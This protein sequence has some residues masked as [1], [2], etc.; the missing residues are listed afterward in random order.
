M[1]WSGALAG[2]EQA[3]FPMLGGLLPYAEAVFNQRQVPVLISELDRLPDELRG[4]WVD[5]V[6]ILGQVVLEGPHRYLWFVGD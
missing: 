6:R 3:G 4:P 2:L 5:E 1:A